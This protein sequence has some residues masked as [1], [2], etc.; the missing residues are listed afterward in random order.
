MRLEVTQILRS[1]SAK[2]PPE[3]W[4]KAGVDQPCNEVCQ[5][6]NKGPCDKVNMKQI[7]SLEKLEAL[8]DILQ[9]PCEDPVQSP[10]Q[11]RDQPGAPFV[12]GI[13]GTGANDCY[14]FDPSSTEEVDCESEVHSNSREPLCL[15]TEPVTT[16]ENENNDNVDDTGTENVVA[17]P[18]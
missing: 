10:P 7:N 5:A 14:Y 16:T 4:F 13:E 15:C 1:Q 9:I 3:L 18:A 12:R 6:N 8:L 17:A 11:T 2:G